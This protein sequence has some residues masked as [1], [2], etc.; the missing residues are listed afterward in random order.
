M[1]SRCLAIFKILQNPNHNL[2]RFFQRGHLAK[3]QTY[4]R[5]DSFT[6]IKQRET[7]CLRQV[8]LLDRSFSRKLM[9]RKRVGDR[10]R[11][12]LQPHTGQNQLTTFM[13]L[14]SLSS[15]VGGMGSLQISDNWRVKLGRMAVPTTGAEVGSEG[16]CPSSAKHIHVFRS[17]AC[18]S[19]TFSFVG[20]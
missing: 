16:V 8:Y 20:V 18:F 17:G 11:V 12:L 13:S 14:L 6:P 5:Y 9:K 15:T 7:E 2:A 10:T 19:T 1:D 3:T 4:S